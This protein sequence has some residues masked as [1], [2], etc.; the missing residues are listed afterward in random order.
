MIP[1]ILTLLLYIRISDVY[2]SNQNIFRSFHCTCLSLLSLKNTMYYGKEILNAAN[3]LQ[4][5]YLSS[6][7]S[8]HQLDE[9]YNIYA[10]KDFYLK[11]IV[12]YF[13]V[14]TLYDLIHCYKRIDLLIHHLVCLIWGYVNFI[15]GIG[16]I[17]FNILSEGLT[18]AY[19]ISTFKNQ[20]IYRLLFT[21]FIR[22]PVWTVGGYYYYSCRVDSSCTFFHDEV[23]DVFN[24][25]CV[26]CMILMDYL[27]SKQN[28][29]KLKKIW[30]EVEDEHKSLK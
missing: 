20:L 14:Y 7:G 26:S 9:V 16:F 13:I 4:R 2:I 17:S 21:C 25:I 3:P 23:A 10:H 18:F 8:D 22:F 29:K 24:G 12:I 27:W 15:Y 19:N 6:P 1:E 30:N 5:L 11:F 28:Y